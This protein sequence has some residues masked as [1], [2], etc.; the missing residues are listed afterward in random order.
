MD[1][2]FANTANARVRSF[3]SEAIRRMRTA[4]RRR[5]LLMVGAPVLVLAA[6]AVW[7]LASA[8]AVSTD[9]ATV[10][11]ARAPI[12]ASVRG[13]VVEILVSDNQPVRAGDPLVRLDQGDFQRA[14]TTAEARL[15]AARL[16]VSALRATYQEA[17]AGRRA[18]QATA[19][20]ARAEARRQENLFRAG[21]VSRQD[22]DGARVQADVTARQAAAATEG[23]AIAL[24][25]LGGDPRADIDSH[26]LVMQALAALEDARSDLAD[27]EI[28]APADGVVARISQVQ[29]GAYVQPAQTLFYVV[30]GEPWIEA[31]FKE[32]QIEN[33]RPGQPVRIRIDA[34]PGEAFRGHVESFSPGTGSSF[35]VLPAENATGNWVR[36]VQRLSVRIAFDEAPPDAALAM[37]L[38]ARVDV[39]TRDHGDAL[40]GRAR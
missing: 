18:A 19:A 28:K 30:S 39:N 29:L 32:N 4:D 34:F 21:V 17:I 3:A 12:S 7:L 22:L 14:V 38:S 2:S 27:T 35:A 16:Q 20:H 25:N 31:A 13:R 5:L 11:A 1:G 9:N 37:G 8:G 36:V 15:A 6:V 40:R 24:A 26:P 23:E 33:L 10:T